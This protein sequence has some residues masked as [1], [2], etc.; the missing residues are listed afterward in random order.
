MAP[1]Q[2][3]TARCFDAAYHEIFN[4]PDSGPVFTLLQGW[5]GLQLRRAEPPDIAA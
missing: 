4:E 1:P 3:V 5:L 2:I